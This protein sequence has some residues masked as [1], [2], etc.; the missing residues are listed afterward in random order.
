MHSKIEK[1]YSKIPTSQKMYIQEF[2]D[3]HTEKSLVVKGVPW[4]YLDS[5]KG[6]QA[7]LLLHGGFADYSMWIHQ[8]VA[9][10]RTYRILAPTC[11]AWQDAKMGDYSQALRAILAAEKVDKVYMMGYS[12]GGLIAQCFL[13]DNPNM[14]DKVI[15]GHTFYPSV[16]N[17]YNRYDFNLFRIL[18]PPLTESIFRL[19]AKPDKEEIQHQSTEWLAWYQGWFRELKSKLTKEG[20]LTHI[21]LMIDFVRNYTF[22]PNDLSGWAGKMLITVS[23]DDIVLRYYDGMKRL[24]PQAETHIFDEGLGAHSVA[25]ITPGVFNQRISAFLAA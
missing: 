10:E 12:E 13:R 5:G 19:L 2:E 18:P 25:L 6:R 8:I 20:I 9:F 17:Q 16:E 4:K 1:Y 21:D 3:T 7:L 15:L 23:A 22:T 14:I 24:Y 11:P